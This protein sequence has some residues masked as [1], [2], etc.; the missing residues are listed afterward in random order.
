V[1]K[2]KM[3]EAFLNSPQVLEAKKAHKTKVKTI[4]GEVLQENIEDEALRLK[5]F[6]E[7]MTQYTEIYNVNNMKDMI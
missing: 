6:E 7:F 4:L 3:L 2:N 1:F 5:I